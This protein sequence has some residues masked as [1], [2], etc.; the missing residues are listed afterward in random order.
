MSKSHSKKRNSALVYEFL[1]RWMSTALVEGRDSEAKVALGI[2]K[3]HY[4][5]GTE[6][7][8]EYRLAESLVKATVSS[9][10]TA[11][12][13]LS[14]AK[15]AA[16]AH[17]MKRLNEEKFRLITEIHSTVKDP[18][19]WDRPVPLYKTIAT[20]QTL[21]NDWRKD[22]RDID[23][24]R[25]AEYEDQIVTWLQ[26]RKDSP[27][28]L[29]EMKGNAGEDRLILRIMSRKLEE[30]YGNSLTAL[31][32]T[33]MKEYILMGGKDSACPQFL[34]IVEQMTKGLLER[35]DVYIRDRSSQDYEVKKLISLK[36][37]IIDG[38][39]LG[40]SAMGTNE[41]WFVDLMDCAKLHDELGSEE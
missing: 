2:I 11:A 31:Q 13:I 1:V 6:L 34:P 3:K 22:P 39:L 18:L 30:K 5:P 24:I 17:D 15:R 23:L 26:E 25:L 9:S 32:R 4:R 28:K 41:N 29:E 36:E 7:Y 21:I 12:S 16:R 27:K 38:S 40:I 10:G 20:V 19:F 35:I 33:I 8:K 14:E 37:T